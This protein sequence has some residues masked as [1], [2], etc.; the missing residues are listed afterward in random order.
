VINTGTRY[1]TLVYLFIWY[2]FENTSQDE[3]PREDELNMLGEEKFI[4]P[5]SKL[6]QLIQCQRCQ[7]CGNGVDPST[8]KSQPVAAGITYTF[9][10]QVH[11]HSK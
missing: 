10:C 2:S 8:V 6:N 5:L 1:Q 4:V 3:N 11:L 7:I 9:S